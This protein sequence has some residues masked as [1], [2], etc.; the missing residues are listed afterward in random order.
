MFSFVEIFIRYAAAVILLFLF[1]IRFILDLRCDICDQRYSTTDAL[2]RH[3]QIVHEGIIPYKCNQCDKLFSRKDLL[4]RHVVVHSEIKPFKCSFCELSFKH[5]RNQRQHEKSIHR[6][7]KYFCPLCGVQMSRKDQFVRHL[8]N[9][10]PSVSNGFL[11][12]LES[13]DCPIQNDNFVGNLP[14]KHSS[15]LNESSKGLKSDNL[16]TNLL[17]LK[18]PEVRSQPSDIAGNPPKQREFS[19]KRSIQE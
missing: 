19:G 4:K 12:G 1:V 9:K 3:K 10:H 16:Q 14:E 8:R 18:I 6:Q 15:T 13:K 11:M 5:L 17:K 2:H 7:V